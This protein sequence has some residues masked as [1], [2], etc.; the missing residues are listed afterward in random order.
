MQGDGALHFWFWVC[1]GETTV[2]VVTTMTP[3]MQNGAEWINDNCWFDEPMLWKCHTLR[4]ALDQGHAS[5]TK[6]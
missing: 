3:A 1:H 4:G 5:Q 2:A 6:G